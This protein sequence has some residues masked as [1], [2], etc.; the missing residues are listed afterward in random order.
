VIQITG[1]A[2]NADRDAV[3]CGMFSSEFTVYCWEFQTFTDVLQYLH[4]TSDLKVIIVN[5]CSLRIINTY[6]ATV[7][8]SRQL[9]TVHWQTPLTSI[10][11]IQYT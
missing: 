5:T 9:I 4:V 11:V 7:K 8:L 2:L 1:S 6:G 3:L 10:L